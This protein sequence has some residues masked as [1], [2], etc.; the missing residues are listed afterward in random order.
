MTSSD[1]PVLWEITSDNHS[2][3]QRLGRTLG[4]RMAGGEIILLDGPMGAGK[5]CLTGG[6]AEGMGIAEPLVSPTYVI[7]REY[8]AESGLTLYHLDFYRLSGSV[9][10]DSVGLED[11]YGER[12]VIVI[13][14]PSRCP[15]ALSEFSLALQMDHAGPETRVIQAL[16]GSARLDD[17]LKRLSRQS[18]DA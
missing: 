14:W 4:R 18:L 15:D 13:E 16:A 5:T 10:L 8:D 1:P 9:D 6:L 7:M 17:S 3:T 11:C 2:E 12:S